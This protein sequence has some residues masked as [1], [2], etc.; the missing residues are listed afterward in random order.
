MEMEGSMV[1]ATKKNNNNNLK[2]FN[3]NLNVVRWRIRQNDRNTRM[4]VGWYGECHYELW[5]KGSISSNHLNSFI[6]SF[7][8]FIFVILYYGNGMR[9]NRFHSRGWRRLGFYFFFV[10]E[11]SNQIT[12]GY[13]FLLSFLI[14]DFSLFFFLFLLL[15]NSI[16]ERETHVRASKQT[17]IFCFLCVILPIAYTALLVLRITTVQVG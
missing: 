11:F 2:K 17:P 4:L 7:I 9:I 8:Q 15:T 14:V 16:C 6:H 5:E 10:V 13:F 12:F 1:T 3:Y